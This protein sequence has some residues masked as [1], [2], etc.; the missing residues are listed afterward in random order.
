MKTSYVVPM[1]CV[2]V[3]A[4]ALTQ[5]Y[6]GQPADLPTNETN[7]T[8]LRRIELRDDFSSFIQHT[9]ADIEK[10]DEIYS[11]IISDWLEK[12]HQ[13]GFW[14]IHEKTLFRVLNGREPAQGF[15]DG[16]FEIKLG[17]VP[18]DIA[19]IDK[20]G[21]ELIDYADDLAER[22]DGL[23]AYHIGHIVFVWGYDLLQRNTMLDARLQGL[24]MLNAGGNVM[25]KM[26]RQYP[27]ISAKVEIDENVLLEL[28]DHVSEIDQ[29]WSKKLL[30]VRSVTPHLGDLMHIA[31]KDEDLTFRIEGVLRLGLFQHAAKSRGNLWKMQ[32]LIESAQ[33]DENI[34]IQ[35]AGHRAAAFSLN[36]AK[37]FQ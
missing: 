37:V 11:T 36:D 8:V 7:E 22:G 33:K 12:K 9:N 31:E 23:N 18:S 4:A 5:Y 35:K 14:K 10:R 13:A 32:Q 15:M 20:I 34:L 28:S 19:A 25:F 21:S 2:I 29:R 26:L 1:I 16:C 30:L 27:K 6:I 24:W 3:I 17:E